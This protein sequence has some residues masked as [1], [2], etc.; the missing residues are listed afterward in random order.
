VEVSAVRLV[1]L[2]L[3]GLCTLPLGLLSLRPIN[4][5]R[6]PVVSLS[7]AHVVPNR[8]FAA[9]SRYGSRVG[10]FVKMNGRK[11]ER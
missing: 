10:G 6:A 7:D 3:A 2:F 1:R 11:Y 5:S 9:E 8:L 4:L